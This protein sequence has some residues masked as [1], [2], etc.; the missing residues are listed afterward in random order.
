MA[1]F[2]EYEAYDALGLADLVRRGRVTAT[3]LLE[4]AIE[5]VEARNPSINA[6]VLPLYEHARKA[7]ADGLPDGPLRGVPYLLKDLT[8]SL[9]GVRTTRGSRFFADTPP[10]TAD[11]EHVARLKRAGLVIFGRTST[12][13]LGLSLTCEPR[14]YGPTRNP[15]DPTRISGGSSGG[16]AAATGAR[17]VP[18]AHASDG[19]GSIR[20]PAA[21]CGLVGLKPT[22]ARNTMA[23]YTGEGLAGLSTEHAVTLTVRDSAA[24]LDATAGPGPGDPYTAPAPAR[25]FLSEAGTPPGRL[26]IAWTVR[27]PNGAPVDPACVALVREVAA[28]CAGLGHEVAEADPEIDRDLVIPTFLTIAAANSAANVRTHPTAGR[29]PRRGE[30]E[31]VTFDTA[32]RGETVAAP[33]YVRATQAAHR[34]GRQMAAFHR[35]WDVLLTPALATAGAVKLGWIDMMLED[36]DE[37]WRRVFAFSPFTVWFNITGQ[38]AMVLPLGRTEGSGGLPL[39][40]QLVARFGD[41]AAL[42]RLGA[43]LEAARPWFD[44]RPAL[45][46]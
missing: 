2:T 9:A 14:L 21:C 7:I 31:N 1:G 22:R 42:F 13:E 41:E 44:R 28:L 40:I 24:L 35:A 32:A 29:P 33:D 46:G 27:P 34:L 17:I 25:P 4:A 3:D 20:A 10:A 18:I 12:C 45:A 15:W 36:V 5:R 43:Q 11:S 39:A 16:A 26:R 30:V 6:V 37:Y 8:A 38:P 19:F 23:P